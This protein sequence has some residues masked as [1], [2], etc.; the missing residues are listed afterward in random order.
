MWI[1]V[2]RVLLLIIGAIIV[3]LG[4]GTTLSALLGYYGVKFGMIAMG[5]LMGILLCAL[6]A[7]FI[8]LGMRGTDKQVADT[9]LM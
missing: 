8:Y 5:I 7:F 6:G 2:K 4:A 3:V 9:D 1:K